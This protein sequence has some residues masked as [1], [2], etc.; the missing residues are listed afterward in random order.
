[1]TDHMNVDEADDASLPTSALI[2]L[3]KKS[4]KFFHFQQIAK[5]FEIPEAVAAQHLGISKTQLKKLCREHDIPRWPYRRVCS[6]CH[7]TNYS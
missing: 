7:H 1:M 3:K 5:H 6:I 4:K 2:T